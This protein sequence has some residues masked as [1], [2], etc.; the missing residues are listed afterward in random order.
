M[1]LHRNQERLFGQAR[2]E[3]KSAIER[4]QSE[5]VAVGFAG[6]RAG[7]AVADVVE[8]VRAL[9]SSLV[10]EVFGGGQPFEELGDR[11]GEVVEGTVSPVAGRSVGVVADE[12]EAAAALWD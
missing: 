3:P 11:G 2:L 10:E 5:E 7:A 8:R 9:R 12:G 4:I 1:P 6:R